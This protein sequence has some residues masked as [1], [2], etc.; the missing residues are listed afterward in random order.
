MWAALSSMICVAFSLYQH[1]QMFSN[2]IS[3]L[4]PI[5]NGYTVLGIHPKGR[6]AKEKETADQISEKVISEI[7]LPDEKKIITADSPIIAIMPADILGDMVFYV[8]CKQHNEK[9]KVGID[10]VQRFAGVIE[11]DKV[12]GGI[13]ATT[14][15]FKLLYY[16]EQV[17]S[18]RQ[19]D[20]LCPFSY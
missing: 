18:F 9:N 16:E 19:S 17:I 12:N 10:I 3:A 7:Y 14:S 13:I 11:I 8:E 4:Q 2:F 5:L 20:T 15:F 1:R 6:D